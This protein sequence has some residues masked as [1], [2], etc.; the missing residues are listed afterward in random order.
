MEE[1]RTPYI[2]EM[3]KEAVD[4]IY[5]GEKIGYRAIKDWIIEKYGEKS[6]NALNAQINVCIVNQPGR[7]HY[8]ENKKPRIA[9]SKYDFLYLIN[10]GKVVK[11]DPE[12]HGIW[13]I[14]ENE[15]GKLEV[16]LVS[17][18]DEEEFT[19]DE[20]SEP[21]YLFPLESNLRDFL[22]KN[23]ATIPFNGK[24]LHLYQDETGRDGVEYPTEVGRIDV[25][26][27]DE[28]G[29]FVVF[30][31]KL[32]KGPDR[33][34]GQILRYMGWVKRKIANSKQTYGVIVAKRVDK[35]L[36]YAINVTENIELFEYEL[37]FRINQVDKI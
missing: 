19:T 5:Q 31:L 21:E 25:L 12:E 24:K 13:E 9:N 8:P 22:A 35:K 26:A 2:W 14:R 28:E 6:D 1:K 16:G 36:R 29:N 15:F 30:E 10:K 7:I 23:I 32:D 33:A 20:E 27:Q 18:T 34:L 4:A 11:Y 3:I 37:D 17:D